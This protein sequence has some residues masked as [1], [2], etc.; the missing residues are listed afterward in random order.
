[1]DMV[2]LVSIHESLVVDVVDHCG[3][4][5][6]LVAVLALAVLAIFTTVWM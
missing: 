2:V 1:M 4:L 5:F 6:A 3:G